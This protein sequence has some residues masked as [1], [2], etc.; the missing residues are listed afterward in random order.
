[1]K[2]QF[3]FNFESDFIDQYGSL[4]SHRLQTLIYP[5]YQ[6]VDLSAGLLGAII[7]VLQVLAL[8]AI[9]I[10]SILAFYCTIFRV[11]TY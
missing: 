5:L 8:T 10:C 2:P 6:S 7:H 11:Q 4:I 3:P 1:M 9:E